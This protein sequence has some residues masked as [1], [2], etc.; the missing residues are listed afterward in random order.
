MDPERALDVTCYGQICVDHIFQ[1]GACRQPRLGRETYAQSYTTALGG[2]AGIVAITLARLGLRSALVS[3]VGADAA[4]IGL[5]TQLR[6]ERVDIEHVEVLR[7][8]PTDVSV[9]FTCSEDRGFLSHAAASRALETV[10]MESG[11][12]ARN[13][14]LH[15]CLSQTDD[16]EHW[17]GL[18]RQAHEVGA[19]VSIDLGWQEV[20]DRRWCAWMGEADIVFPNEAEALRLAHTRAL[21]RAMAMLGACGA[22]VVVK[23]GGAG[24]SAYHVG[25]RLDVPPMPVRAVVDTTGAGD[26]FAAGFLWAYLRG[27]S[28]CAA[29]AAGSLCGARCVEQPG[30]LAIPPTPDEL[31]RVMAAY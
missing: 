6:A 5:L 15:L 30:G 12:L 10:R 28:L 29:L 2:G 24:V 13:R 1:T 11:C 9:A 18:L 17:R 31:E 21:D 27:R 23:R 22:I 25:T 14:H 8:K 4:G 3:R 7:D 16:A 20:W 26:M 19:T